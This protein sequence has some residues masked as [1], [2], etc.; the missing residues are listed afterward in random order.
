MD[1]QIAS[2]EAPRPIQPLVIGAGYSVV[3]VAWWYVAA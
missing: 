3:V 2:C 1:A